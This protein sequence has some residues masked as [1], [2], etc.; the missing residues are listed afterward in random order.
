M[1]PPKRGFQGKYRFKLYDHEN[2]CHIDLTTDEVQVA[3]LRIERFKQDGG[4]HRGNNSLPDLRQCDGFVSDDGRCRF[5]V[6]GMPGRNT[7]D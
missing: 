2:E 6:R 3:F 4:S 7:G 1:P 5:C